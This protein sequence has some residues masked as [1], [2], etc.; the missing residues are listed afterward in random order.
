MFW[1]SSLF[2]FQE[3]K[4]TR[5][6]QGEGEALKSCR[7]HFLN[8]SVCS[9]SK[10]CCFLTRLI[11]GVALQRYTVLCNRE[12]LYCATEK[13]CCRAFGGSLKIWGQP[14]LVKEREKNTN[15]ASQHFC[16]LQPSWPS[17][18]SFSSSFF[19]CLSISYTFPGPRIFHSHSR[20]WNLVME[21]SVLVPEVQNSFPLAPSLYHGKW[22]IFWKLLHTAFR[23]LF[24]R[25][26]FQSV[27]Y[28]VYFRRVFSKVYLSKVYFYF[29]SAK[30]TRLGSVSASSELCEFINKFASSVAPISKTGTR[31]IKC[32]W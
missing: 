8:S 24:L 21:F 10:C 20:S 13:Y 32:L 17:K 23:F 18:T 15:Q 16:I 25:C 3:C 11:W 22:Y 27:H 14:T 12:I 5:A 6:R 2:C 19:L 28:T 30:C 1:L 7:G 9:L 26:I 31:L 4:S 29:I